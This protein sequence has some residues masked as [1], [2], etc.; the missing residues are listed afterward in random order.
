MRSTVKTVSDIVPDRY[1]LDFVMGQNGPRRSVSVNVLPTPEFTLN[2][3][4]IGEDGARDVPA[5]GSFTV[6]GHGLFANSP[7]RVWLDAPDD[8]VVDDQALDTT[9]QGSFAHE[10]HVPTDATGQYS[11]QIQFFDDPFV[12]PVWYYVI[13]VS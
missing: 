9:G 10:I 5:G 1:D 3:R 8:S 2:G 11:L 7:I 4:P 6:A 13:N 12:R